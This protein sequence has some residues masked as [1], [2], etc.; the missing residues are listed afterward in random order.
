MIIAKECKKIFCDQFPTIS[1][2]LGGYDKEWI[3]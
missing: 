3:V 2:A 1:E